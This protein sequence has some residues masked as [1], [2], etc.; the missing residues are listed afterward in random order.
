[1][2]VV[3]ASWTTSMK[4]DESVRKDESE[5]E[6]PAIVHNYQLSKDN[7]KIILPY[8]PSPSRGVIVDKIANRMDID[9]MEEGLR[10]HSVEYFDPEKYY[11]EEGQYISEEVVKS[12]LSRKLTKKQLEN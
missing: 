12:W 7:Y 6:E 8:R 3:A 4:E 5:A 9:E 2:L 10:R 11:F 1:Q